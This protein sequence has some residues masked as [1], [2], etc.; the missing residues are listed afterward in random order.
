M[1]KPIIR[2]HHKINFST[3]KVLVQTL[4]LS[5]VDYCNSLLLGMSQY[6]LKTLQNPKHGCTNYTLQLKIQ[7]NHTPPPR[8]ALIND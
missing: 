2:V 5:Q 3:A 4:V 8:T 1:L 7:Q 6:N